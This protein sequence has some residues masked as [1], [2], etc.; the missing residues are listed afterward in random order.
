MLSGSHLLQGKQKN[1]AI[2]NIKK[3]K[4]EIAFLSSAN[5]ESSE[6]ISSFYSLFD[7]SWLYNYFFIWVYKGWSSRAVKMEHIVM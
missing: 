7:V 4:C 5:G 2:I 1:N 6:A 3:I